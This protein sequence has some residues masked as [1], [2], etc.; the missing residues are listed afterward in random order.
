MTM[1]GTQLSGRY[2]LESKL[3]SGGM[4][5]VYL[6]VDETLDRQVAI[7]IMHRE[8]SQEADQLERFRREA[9]AV[10]SLSHPNLVAVIDAGEDGGHPY[11]V[12]EYVPGE[13]LKKRLDDDGRLGLDE[14]TAYAIEIGRGLA[15]AHSA[16]LIHRDVKPQNVLI[17]AE[18]RAKITDFGIARSLEVHGLTATGRVLGTTDYVSPEQ[19]MGKPVDSRTDVYSLGILLYE[20][21]TGDVPFH[22]ETQV[23]VAMKHVND[24]VPDVQKKRPETSAALA[25]ALERAVAKQ[26]DD[27]YANMNFFLAD[28][29]GALEVEV[30]RAGHATGEATTVLD[31]VPSWRRKLLTRRRISWAGALLLI[32]AAGTAIALAAF[33]GNDEPSRG[34]DGGGGGSGQAVEILTVDDFDPL[35]GDGEERSDL[36]ENAVDGNPAGTAWTTETYESPD[37]SGIKDGVGLVIE[38][39]GE[40]APREIVITSAEPGWTTEIYG[41]I[42]T[43]PPSDLAGWGKPLAG[44]ITVGSDEQ[45]IEQRAVEP[46]R[47]LLIWITGL[48]PSPD[49]DTGFRVEISDVRLLS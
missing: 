46:S 28:L 21:L 37:F 32:A 17:D 30:A 31:S 27:R 34:A 35:P 16:R 42:E 29:E 11:I 48:A 19:A 18:G 7:K 33:T 14:A 23:G 10:A 9:R 20:M 8:I 49:G 2:R 3:G 6:A 36:L 22:A 41:S 24:A 45:T 43:A 13:T 38:A 5:T 47:W 40:V 39:D 25:A 4:S 26:P 44:P 12:F 15:S 1:I